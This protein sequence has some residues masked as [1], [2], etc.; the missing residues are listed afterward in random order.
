[1]Q[2][3]N[4]EK[5]PEEYNMERLK[6]KGINLFLQTL[7]YGTGIIALIIYIIKQITG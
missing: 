4:E 1:M 6:L 5:T 7:L 2:I 3:E